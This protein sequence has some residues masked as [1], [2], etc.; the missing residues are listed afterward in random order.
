MAGKTWV[1]GVGKMNAVGNAVER[2]VKS[3]AA[4]SEAGARFDAVVNGGERPGYCW[5]MVEVSDGRAYV[6][7]K[8]GGPR[9]ASDL[10]DMIERLLL[11]LLEGLIEE[12]KRIMSESTP[13]TTPPTAAT[14][15][16]VDMDGDPIREWPNTS[17][18]DSEW[19]KEHAARVRQARFAAECETTQ[20]MVTA[21]AGS[22]F[23]PYAGGEPTAH[24]LEFSR[25]SEASTMLA[26]D[27]H[28]GSQ[29]EMDF[30]RAW[31]RTK[32]KRAVVGVLDTG[33]RVTHPAFAGVRIDV[34]DCVGQG[35]HLA[36]PNSHGTF[37]TSQIVAKSLGSAGHGDA[38]DVRIVV[39]AVMQQPQGVGADSWIARG[40]RALVDSGCTVI[41]GSI[42]GDS[43]MPL[44][45]AAIKYGISKGVVFCFATGNSGSE[46]GQVAYPA[47]YAGVIGVGSCRRHLEQSSF[48]QDGEGLDV[49]AF[50]EAQV[51]AVSSGGFGQ[52]DGT[53]MAAPHVTAA[54]ALAHSAATLA[55]MP[56]DGVK[57]IEDIITLT[58]KGRSAGGPSGGEWPGTVQAGGMVETVPTD[59]PK[60][61]DPP[62]PTP[63]DPPT[64]IVIEVRHGD[65]KGEGD[66]IRAV[67]DWLATGTLIPLT[68]A[69]P[70]SC[71]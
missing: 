15:P 53:S 57:Q 40:V 6:T 62:A 28:T 21:P 7:E 11:R 14:P 41:N 25:Q 12:A 26:R 24:T 23:S 66:A 29:E 1:W 31:T 56:V 30:P 48:S 59:K 33:C 60:P 64:G 54:V 65:R 10:W 3:G 70:K 32:G 2:L 16:A 61:V 47:R 63:V 71:E 18:T 44:T 43:P 8:G 36:D 51:G 38:P 50:G 19:D 9:V 4:E 34:I 58:G 37:V 68:L 39:A 13:V 46:M 52:W 69:R 35:Q 55:G 22:L 17:L 67:F 45:E 42:G 49:Y 20:A 27:L 5:I